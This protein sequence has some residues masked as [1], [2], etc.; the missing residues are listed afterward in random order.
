MV[1]KDIKP[2]ERNN[3][4]KLIKRISFYGDI[5]SEAV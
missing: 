4:F 3:L 1:L 2:N 5:S